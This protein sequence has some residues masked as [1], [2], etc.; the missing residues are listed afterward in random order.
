MIDWVSFSSTSV[1]A[2]RS[3]LMI[4]RQA[5]SDSRACAWLRTVIFRD[6]WE[7]SDGTGLEMCGHLFVLLLILDGLGVGGAHCLPREAL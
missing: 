3:P 4:S 1:L 7:G 5:M 6:I 2:S